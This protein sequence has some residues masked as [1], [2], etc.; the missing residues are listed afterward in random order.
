[1][2]TRFTPL[3][4]SLLLAAC[5]APGCAS[6][7]WTWSKKKDPLA[8]VETPAKRVE[9][10][11]AL[12]QRAP[13]MPADEQERESARLVGELKQEL[14]PAIR[15][16]IIRTLAM[17]PTEGATAALSAALADPDPRVKIAACEAW[18]K[19]GGPEAAA[20]LA[21]MLS[22]HTRPN[23]KED[24]DVRLAATRALGDVGDQNAMAGL[25]LALEDPNPAMQY[26]AV[27]SLQKV[28]GKKSSNVEAWRQAVKSPAPTRTTMRDRLRR[29]F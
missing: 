13:K 8:N 19:R 10:M 2:A 23:V 20:S 26:R 21:E 7:G 25:A 12:A 27:E 11:K 24:C 16:H 15:A 14:D 17:F 9:K 29:L 5:A 3:V 28:T 1:M 18:G 6:K 22:D 4:L